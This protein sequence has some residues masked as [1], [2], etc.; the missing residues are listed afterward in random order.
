MVTVSKKIKDLIKK[1]D[2]RATYDKSIPFY[3]QWRRIVAEFIGTLLFIYAVSASAVIPGNYLEATSGVAVI[4]TALI[5]GFTLIAAVSI[6][7]GFSGSHFNPAI[8]VMSV[9]IRSISPVLAFF[10]II[11]QM[12]GAMC[13]AGL[14]RA[15]VNKWQYLSATTVSPDIS[16]GQAF[17]IEFMITNILLFVVCITSTTLN[18]GLLSLAPIPIGMAVTIGVLIANN[19]TGASMNPC[20]SFGPAVVAG[21]WTNHWIYWAAPMTSAVLVALLWIVVFHIP[22]QK[23]VPPPNA[24]QQQAPLE[25]KDTEN[26]ESDE[27]DDTD[28]SVADDPAKGV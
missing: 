5:Q 23:Q 8:T 12:C 2:F 16:V 14:F 1:R 25:V 24:P 27:S 21:V 17:L 11:A 3:Y 6:F 18:N 4:V 13:G 7:A 28:S 15:S 20:R 19:L 22:R 10:Y 26:A 9:L